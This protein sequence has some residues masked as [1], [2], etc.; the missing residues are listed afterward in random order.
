M[1][2]YLLDTSLAVP[3]RDRDLALIERVEG[4]AGE[5]LFS[6][7]TKV[8]LESGVYR[9]PEHAIVRR[10]R[11]DALLR[12]IPVLS[13]EDADANA[14]GSI[15]AVAGFSRRKIIDRMIAAQAL[16]HRATLVTLNGADFEDVPG[17]K[18]LAW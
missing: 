13:F 8:E 4:L 7:I 10:T 1:S 15:V 11:V 16:V 6:V 17:L 12:T 14:Y 18:L 5:L 2:R 9:Q 3:L